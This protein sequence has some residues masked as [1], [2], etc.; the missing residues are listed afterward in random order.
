MKLH[1]C[2]GAGVVTGVN[3]LLETKAGKILVDCGLFQGSRELEKENFEAFSYNPR[4]IK[5]VIVTHSHLDHIGRLPQLVKFGFTGKI[6][7]TPPT[8]DFTHLILDDS[9]RVLEEKANKA[10][11]LPLFSRFEVDELMKRFVPVDYYKKT[12][13]L[14]N[15]NFTYH[16]AGHILGSAIVDLE[17]IEKKIY[18]EQSR[19]IVF[20]G[21][22]GNPP[23]PL[24]RPPDFLAEADY[25]LVESTYGDRNHESPQE[26]KDKIERV[27]EDAMSRG[28][29]LLI[30]SFALERTQQLL[31]HFNDLVEHHRIPI[32]PVYIDSP[33]ATRIT[34]VYKKYPQYFNR[35]TNSEIDSGDDIFNFPGLR[36]TMSSKES[37]A[38]N[39]TKPPKIIIAGSGMSQ[40]GRIVHHEVRYLSDPINTLL[41]VTY[42]A[43]GTL[44][45]KI[46]EGAKKVEI[47]DQEVVIR[48]R[49]EKISGYSAHADQRFLMN[50]LGHFEKSSYGRGNNAGIK[51]VF[52]VQGE[53]EAANTLGSLIRDELGVDSQIPGR[54][55]IAGI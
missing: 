9:V 35:E 36:F 50:W 22:L 41:L 6:Y 20:S 40:G 25:V 12:E 30:P 3:Y 28:G 38:I 15:V 32:V 21:D 37:K 29:V 39:D 47:L 46:A 7:A 53:T 26:C 45:R 18:P 2:G 44:G 1:F 24:L 14:S 55:D 16:D 13:I 23:A 49:V 17:V 5:A 54:N 51:K 43:D 8:I 48:A 10:D 52:V 42:Q 11:V 31:Y 27:I 19:R 33:L 4:E 34:E